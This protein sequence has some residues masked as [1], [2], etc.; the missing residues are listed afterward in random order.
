MDPKARRKINMRGKGKGRTYIAYLYHA[1]QTLGIRIMANGPFK[2]DIR[3]GDLEGLERVKI[4]GLFNDRLGPNT[5]ARLDKDK[6][7]L[8]EYIKEAV[9]HQD[10]LKIVEKI[11]SKQ[12]AHDGAY[13]AESR[14]WIRTSCLSMPEYKTMIAAAFNV[15]PVKSVVL[16]W[17][18]RGETRCDNCP[19]RMRKTVKHLFCRCEH[20][21]FEA[22][23]IKR[24]NKVV[25]ELYCWVKLRAEN[26]KLG[27]LAS[28]HI[29]MAENT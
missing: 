26:G 13:A 25:C 12:F 22:I 3:N 10:G 28:F 15:L 20:P 4:I 27:R 5:Q 8:K 1:C 29:W 6:L 24:H 21:L 14:K 17:M 2:V 9:R 16:T 19:G 23:R 11:A 18:R 7:E